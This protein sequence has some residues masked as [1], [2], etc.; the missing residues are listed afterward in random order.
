MFLSQ[1]PCL[2]FELTFCNFLR[3]SRNGYMDDNTLQ[4]AY[5]GFRLGG[6]RGRIFVSGYIYMYRKFVKMKLQILVK[7]FVF[8]GGTI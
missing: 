4:V 1:L 2:L 3:V 5:A 7:V 8:I 6:G